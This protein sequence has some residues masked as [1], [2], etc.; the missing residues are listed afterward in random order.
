MTTRAQVVTAYNN[1][2][3][4]FDSLLNTAIDG[5]NPDKKTTPQ[6]IA[7]ANDARAKIDALAQDVFA[8]LQALG[9]I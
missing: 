3:A 8:K 9:V 4:N 6:I 2:T 1:F 5:L 7:I